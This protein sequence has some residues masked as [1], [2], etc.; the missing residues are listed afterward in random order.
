[1]LLVTTA[2][3]GLMAGAIQTAPTPAAPAPQQQPPQ[4]QPQEPPAPQTP[5]PQTPPDAGPEAEAN[6]EGAVDLGT[7][8]VS[9]AR[10]RGSVDT[11][12]PPDVVLTSD[13]IMAYGASDI[14]ELLTYLEPITRSSSGRTDLQPVFLVN[15]R[16]ISGFREIRG[17]PTEAIER[18]EIL[19]EAVAVQFG[20][21]PE[22]R[23]VNF[24]LK[25]D[26]RST[27]YELT[28]RVPTQDRKS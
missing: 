12:I 20:Y 5:A 21:R 18:T 23:V 24:V 3:S 15:G 2:L 27:T 16:R 14:S 7:V 25:T 17:I 10:P 19:P 4:Q 13:E 28:G 9:S 22:Q 26:F 11:D 8:N 6:T 1:M